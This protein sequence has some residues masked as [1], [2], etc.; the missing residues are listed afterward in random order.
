[1]IWLL[2]PWYPLSMKLMHGSN[3]VQDIYYP[4]W[5][6]HGFYQSL[7]ETND[8]FLPNHILSSVLYSFCTNNPTKTK[9][10]MS[11]RTVLDMATKNIKCCSQSLQSVLFFYVIYFKHCFAKVC[12]RHVNQV[13]RDCAF[14]D[15]IQP[16]SMVLANFL[17]MAVSTA[18]LLPSYPVST[19]TISMREKWAQYESECLYPVWECRVPSKHLSYD[20]MA[21]C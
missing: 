16:L 11:L 12:V 2:Y 8:S 9:K 3:L 14:V 1:M 17:S 5:G 20:C 21:W 7:Q 10:L 6:F 18:I 15:G 4:D 13:K 19:A